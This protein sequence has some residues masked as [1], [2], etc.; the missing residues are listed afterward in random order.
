VLDTGE[1]EIVF[2]LLKQ[3]MRVTPRQIQSEPKERARLPLPA[4]NR[5]LEAALDDMIERF[6]KT[7][8]YLAK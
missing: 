5:D 7:L 2:A 4:D 8:D 1:D 6:P 3:T